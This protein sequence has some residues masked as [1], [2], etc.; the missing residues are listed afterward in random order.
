MTIIAEPALQAPQ[1]LSSILTTISHVD[2]PDISQTQSERPEITCIELAKK[3]RQLGLRERSHEALSLAL[4]VVPDHID[5]RVIRANWLYEEGRKSEA[6]NLVGD[7]LS[8]DTRTLCTGLNEN[9]VRAVTDLT[10]CLRK[11]HCDRVADSLLDRFLSLEPANSPLRRQFG[12]LLLKRGDYKYGWRERDSRVGPFSCPVWEGESLEGR[13][14]LVQALHGFG[15]VIQF[16]RFL[17]SLKAWGAEVLLEHPPALATLLDGVEGWDHLIARHSAK[18]AFE[19]DFD[20]HIPLMTLPVPLQIDEN[21]PA[22]IPYIQADPTRL[23]RW[24]DRLSGDSRYRVGLVWAG[25]P[26]FKG[27]AER[28]CCL[29][30]FAPL[31]RLSN[32]RFFSLQVGKAAMQSANP[33]DGLELTDL[34]PEL[35]DFADTA[36]AM[37]HLDLIITVDTAV[38]HLAGALGCRVWTLLPY[39]CCWR[40]LEER[41]DTPW[42]TTMRLFRQRTPGDWAFVVSRV[43]RELK[44]M[45]VSASIA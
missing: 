35:N 34:S 17:P 24:R 21:I 28:S 9:L 25:S 12:M 45:S 39:Y 23:K 29:T 14:I 36:A 26:D 16:L 43:Q 13:K 41:E 6:S 30:D 20:C 5:A 10:Q 11:Q 40:W 18:E 22:P 32:V 19:Y 42:Y 44:D 2:S 4:Q 31:A 37:S 27:D 1:S 33:P 8:E 38:A 7:L 15:D 3:F